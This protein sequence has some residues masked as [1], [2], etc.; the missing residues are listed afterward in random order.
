MENDGRSLPP[1]PALSLREREHYWRASDDASRSEFSQTGPWFSLSLRERAGVRGNGPSKAQ[2]AGV[3]QLP[4]EPAF[5]FHYCCPQCQPKL[6]QLP[7]R[8]GASVR[9][10]P[11]SMWRP[12]WQRWG[13]ACCYSTWTRKPTPPVVSAWRRS[14]APALT[15]IGRAHV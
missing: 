13:G 3:L 10:L 2:S 14:K 11:P 6:S 5:R 7:T 4:L 9:P 1:H 8:K 12:A 15:E